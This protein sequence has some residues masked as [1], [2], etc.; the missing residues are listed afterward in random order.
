[1]F[2][3]DPTPAYMQEENCR[4]SCHLR[5]IPEGS[6]IW[7]KCDTILIENWDILENFRFSVQNQNY[8]FWSF[9]PEENPKGCISGRAKLISEMKHRLWYLLQTSCIDITLEDFPGCSQNSQSRGPISHMGSPGWMHPGAPLEQDSSSRGPGCAAGSCGNVCPKV[10]K[11]EWPRSSGCVRTTT[12]MGIKG[13]SNVG[14]WWASVGEV[15]TD[16]TCLSLYPSPTP[17]AAKDSKHFQL[18]V[19]PYDTQ[20]AVPGLAQKQLQ[21]ERNAFTGLLEKHS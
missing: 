7:S 16:L 4:A 15:R 20:L 17:N 12:Q 1:M 21:E 10:Q 14:D 13:D 6:E 8:S 5:I 18:S 19:F 11:R 3:T 9:L 2:C